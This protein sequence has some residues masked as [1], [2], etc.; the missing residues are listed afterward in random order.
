M[1]EKVKVFLINELRDIQALLRNG[2]RSGAYLYPFRVS[3]PSFFV[4]S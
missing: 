3:Y 4:T 2:L 1:S